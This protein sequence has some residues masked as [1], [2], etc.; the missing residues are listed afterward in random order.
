LQA[1]R[2]EPV[3]DFAG[4]YLTMNLISLKG[5]NGGEVSISL[6][7]YSNA[8]ATESDDAN[9]LFAEISISAGCFTGSYPANLT[10]YDFHRFQDSLK[11]LLAKMCGKVVFSTME[12]WLR[13]EIEMTQRG[14]ATISGEAIAEQAPQISLR[15]SFESDQ[16]YLQKTL[17]DVRSA[18]RN[19]PI[20]FPS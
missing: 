2:A 13:L 6:I 17:F 4:G 8:A 16:S 12:G 5:E 10:T 7:D 18:V 15:F 14:S 11:Q 19:F 3:F 9:W 1:I 20:K